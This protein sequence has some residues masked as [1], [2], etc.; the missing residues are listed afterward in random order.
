MKINSFVPENAYNSN[1]N[2]KSCIM[3]DNP[4]L[5]YEIRHT[6]L[7]KLLHLDPYSNRMVKSEG[8]I[9]MLFYESTKLDGIAHSLSPSFTICPPLYASILAIQLGVV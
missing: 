1:E 7:Y 2:A 8:C 6:Y 9:K 5:I 3:S 4:P